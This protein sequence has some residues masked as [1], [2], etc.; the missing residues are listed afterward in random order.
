MASL[1]L[2]HA[3]AA[4]AGY[5]VTVYQQG[6]RLG[7]K[8]ASARNELMGDR[9]EE[10]GLHV[11]SGFYENAFRLVQSVY[12]QLDRPA[13]HPLPTWDAAF[14]PWDNVSW[15]SHIDESWVRVTNNVPANSLVPGHGGNLAPPAVLM[16]RMLRFGLG[17]VEGYQPPPPPAGHAGTSGP[18]V[19]GLPSAPTGNADV[20]V[21][22]EWLCRGLEALADD[23][24]TAGLS[25]LTH[26]GHATVPIQTALHRWIDQLIR[27]EVK[28]SPLL[29]E[30]LAFLDLG[31][32]YV[33]GFGVDGVYSQGFDVI[34]GHEFSDYVRLHGAH[35]L[36]LGSGFVRGAY[37]YIFGFVGGDPTRPNL[38]AGTTLRMLLRLLLAQCGG[39]FWRMNAGAGDC[40]VAPM[41]QALVASG[42]QFQFFHV[43]RSVEV[44]PRT[45]AIT[46]ATFGVQA[47]V[48]GQRATGGAYHPLRTLPNGLEVWP[49][50]PFYEQLDQGTALQESGQNLE[51]AW[52]NWP[53]VGTVTLERG[54]DFDE[55][56][57]GVPV[58][59]L[60]DVAPVVVNASAALQSAIA[61]L[62]TVATQGL[63]LWLTKTTHDVGA[64][65]P[66]T[67]AT[68]FAPPLDTWAD[69]THLLECEDWPV[70]APPRSLH[71]FCGVLNT[72]PLA[73]PQPEP[74]LPAGVH[75]RAGIDAFAWLNQNITSL[76]PNA[77]A[78]G[79]DGFDLEVLYAPRGEDRFD[80]QFWSTNIDPTARYCQSPVNSSRARPA[81]EGTG[82]DGLI[83]VG[84]WVKTGLDYGCIEA[85]VMS[86]LAGAR[87]ISGA[88][89]AIYGETDFP[90][91][92]AGRVT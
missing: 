72:G 85:A 71:Y 79:G 7:G 53:D 77:A 27:D 60:I 76:W 11:W 69:M 12:A 18:A 5:E 51:S 89:I 63:Q 78:P 57:L 81:P 8:L 91:R 35:A 29:L 4:Q 50:N 64:P 26:L 73:A 52:N 90:D 67:I 80:S 43:L 6:W 65:G 13:T 40:V 23:L 86:G 15:F 84:D 25:L 39:V 24:G 70:V 31:L 21:H 54:R 19:D 38:E 55:L 61:A 48:D 10:H 83:V 75:Q 28:A 88:P 59:C 17:L 2:A 9:I 37:S 68:A 82:I 36:T 92:S 42:V 66:A 56:V 1:S 44:D 41:Y 3:L 46:S 14:Q 34:N 47:T 20:T 45:K 22:L 87:A 49:S 30:V 33:R 62:P 32:A 16:A 58:G 74:S